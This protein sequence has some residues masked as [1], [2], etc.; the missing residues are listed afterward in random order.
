MSR[1]VEATQTVYSDCESDGV[2]GTACCVTN[3][4]GSSELHLLDEIVSRCGA[5]KR[6]HA[7][8]LRYQTLPRTSLLGA[9]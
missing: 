5:F 6:C 3:G 1:I 8:L 2:P 4:M 7:Q 9:D